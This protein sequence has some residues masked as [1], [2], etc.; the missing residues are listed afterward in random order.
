MEEGQ[1]ANDIVNHRK[2]SL[3]SSPFFG[4]LFHKMAYINKSYLLE[5]IFGKNLQQILN[6]IV[7]S[8]DCPYLRPKV[9]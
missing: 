5:A 1:G 3:N 4:P 9:V 6:Y 7:I 8:L 2:P